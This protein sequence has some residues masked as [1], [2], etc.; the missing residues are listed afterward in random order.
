MAQRNK[1]AFPLW[2]KV[3]SFLDCSTVT[4]PVVVALVL[5][6]LLFFWFT[7]LLGGNDVRSM[8]MVMVILAPIV[9]LVFFKR[10]RDRI[11]HPMLLLFA[12][13]GL[14]LLSVLWAVAGKFALNEL[15]KIMA[16][17]SM[18]VLLL[19]LIP[20]DRKQGGRNLA[21]VLCGAMG[22]ASFLSIDTL[23]TQLFS[24]PFVE[25]VSG[26]TG[27]YSEFESVAGDARMNS[28]F[29]N[30]N[31][32]AA[33]TGVAV[34]LGLGLLTSTETKGGR[35]V[36]S[37]LLVF[38]SVAFL[39]ANSRG[40][41]GVLGVCFV[42][43]LLLEKSMKKLSLLLTMVAT[44]LCAGG[45]MLLST[46]S[47]ALTAWN[48]VN[49]I[50]L[51]S[52]LIAGV[53]LG[54][55]CCALA[56]LEGK[57]PVVQNS[58]KVT[59]ISLVIIAILLVLVCVFG[60]IAM[61]SHGEPLQVTETG[62]IRAFY[63]EPGEY[64]VT[65]ELDGMM[66]VRVLSQTRELSMQGQY[67]TLYTEEATAHRGTMEIPITVPDGTIAVYLMVNS[68]AG[69]GESNVITSA[70]YA[71]VNGQGEIP[72]GYAYLPES[73]AIRLQ[74]AFQSYSFLQRVLY[75]EDGLKLVA[76]RPILGYGMGGFENAIVSVQTTNYETKYAHNHYLQAMVETGIF[77]LIFFVGLL[78]VSGWAI[79]RTLRKADGHPLAAALGGALLFMAGHA[80][81]EFDFSY[82]A[83]LPLAYATFALIGLCCG[84]GMT[85]PKVEE[86][87][88]KI[89]GVIIQ[90]V[91]LV[92]FAVALGG[93][94]QAKRLAENPTFNSLA[95]AAKVDPFEK[96]DY[97]LSYVMSSLPYQ[98]TDPEIAQQAD[99]YAKELERVSS[100]TIPV[101]LMEYYFQTGRVEQALSM[102]QKYVEYVPSDQEAWDTTFS[103]LIKYEQNDNQVFCS[104]VLQLVE[105]MDQ[106]ND[107]HLG[108][109]VL[110]EEAASL[111]TR[112]GGT[113]PEP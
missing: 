93:N 98:S 100:N 57:L 88:W 107:T 89:A 68:A 76:E 41:M 69:Y 58:K 60:L 112:C 56:I 113:V 36:H 102:G 39:L 110:S 64:T 14:D 95:E 66:R 28:I 29:L 4:P 111:V 49:W 33:C 53:V 65:L 10:S 11:S 82:Y 35:L 37:V 43:Y 44:L 51:V 97:M 13:V 87:Y 92:A 38:N 1:K 2:R 106:W 72:L 30:P 3:Q 40:A 108:T 21:T 22:L 19:I 15:L 62:T 42:L 6:S 61:D 54:G 48:G 109:L 67:D 94:L 59:V 31:I 55:L 79:V 17:L 103:I 83:F 105:M 81:V 18:A 90:C 27:L 99:V 47:G 70:R 46:Q 9:T 80:M 5:Y 78:A 96:T 73:I 71:G 52:T 50:P 77:G 104:G 12:V 91:I 75:V 23:S 86:T 25:L 74:G 26:M 24:G 45:A 84:E 101:Y 20:G 63:P 7:S 34:L 32:F 8:V 16:A 85:I